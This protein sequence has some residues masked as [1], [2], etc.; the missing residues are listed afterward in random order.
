[1]SKHY[2]VQQW[3]LKEQFLLAFILFANNQMS[4]SNQLHWAP[5]NVEKVEL[6]SAFCFRLTYKTWNNLIIFHYRKCMCTRRPFKRW[7]T[8]SRAQPRITLCCG[9]RP[10]R[11]TA[12]SA[13]GSFGGL[14]DRWPTRFQGQILG[15]QVSPVWDEKPIRWSVV[16]GLLVGGAV[17]SYV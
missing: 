17:L 6:I 2:C 10:R 16:L 13:R 1:M 4:T 3:V 5:F 12:T 7:S 9:R 14:P 11:P 8:Q 15:G